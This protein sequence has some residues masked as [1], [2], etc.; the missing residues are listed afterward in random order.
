MKKIMLAAAAAMVAFSGMAGTKA[1]AHRGYWKTEGSAQNSIRAL[2]KADSIGCYGSEFD[3]WLSKDGKL[4]VNHDRVFKGKNMEEST[5]A[6]LTAVKL[7]NGENLPSLEE[8]LKAGAQCKT[9]LILELKSL[10]SPERETRAVEQIVKMV[11][12]MGLQKRMEYIAFSLHACKE[13]VRLAPEG[14][15]VYYLNG[16]LSPKELNDLKMAGLDYHLGIVKNK[17]PEWIGE[18]HDLGMKVNCWTVNNVAD[19]VW[20]VENK[21]DFI[22]TNEPEALLKLLRETYGEK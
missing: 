1:I 12:A 11:E 16:E 9:K 17:Y 15:P 22:T 6:E 4:V 21:V 18:A 3:V 13:F 5:F 14:T 10:S 19:M 2:I 7:D 20:L 8:Y